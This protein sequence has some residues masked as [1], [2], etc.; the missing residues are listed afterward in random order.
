MLRAPRLLCHS[1]HWDD[2]LAVILKLGVAAAKCSLVRLGC[3]LVS[4]PVAMRQGEHRCEA[5]PLWL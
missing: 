2:S 3:T 5:V 4:K 1:A